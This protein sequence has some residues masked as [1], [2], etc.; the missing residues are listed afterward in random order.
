VTAEDYPK[1]RALAP[2][3]AW[4][5]NYFRIT[6]R[7][8]TYKTEVLGGLTTFVSMAYILA[9][10]G[11][12][13]SSP[14]SMSRRASFFA[15]ALSSGIFTLLMGVFVNVPIALAP[16]MG[17]NGYFAS[18]V[19]SQTLTWTDALGA[20]F[21]SG[22]L[23]LALTMTGLRALLFRAIPPHLRAAITVGIGFFLTIIGLKIGE[24]MR[25]S[26]LGMPINSYSAIPFWDYEI[27]IVDFNK[28]PAARVSIIGVM[29]VAFFSALKVP[30]A[31]IIS[32]LLTTF[33]GINYKGDSL[34]NTAVTP[35]KEWHQEG[36]PAW[37]PDLDDIPS[38]KLTFVGVNTEKFW[39][40]VWT[41]LFV[42]LFDSMGTIQAT[43]TRA[44]L[45]TDPVKGGELVNRAMAVDGFGLSLGAIIGSNSITCY[46]ESATGIEAGA[47]TGLASFITGAC[48]L[49]SLCFVAPF[50][51]IIPDAATACAL[52]IVGVYSMDAVKEIDW[53]DFN[54]AFSSFLT[55]ALMGF[56]Y[57]IANGI[58]AGFIWWSF[59]QS[60][61]L[62]RRHP[63]PPP[64]AQHFPNN[65]RTQLTMQ[66]RPVPFPFMT[67]CPPL[68]A[69][70]RW[71]Q[72]YVCHKVLNRPQWAFG[73]DV[74]CTLPHPLLVAM[75]IFMVVR[76]AYLGA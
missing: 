1:A 25:V 74:D 65:H 51:L 62:R 11:V 71:S 15:T 41:F 17:L 16:G 20:V 35:L 29:F 56:T 13:I 66:H 47:R 57:S 43:L 23:Y 9:L 63:P 3:A 34:I 10:N 64:R 5:D 38:G 42:E 18:V 44:H 7:A 28:N 72:Q 30:G 22:I 70:V 21:L 67:P 69:V 14:I 19:A 50:V 58:S 48:F 73:P 26:V 2:A 39:E 31:I 8:S 59:L 68:P 75:S 27:G 12:I 6:D 36:G 33:C 53:K 24:I 37:L 32:I 40:V 54:I 4:V 61:G 76:F 45:M 55:I 52:I 46:I 49:L 60:E